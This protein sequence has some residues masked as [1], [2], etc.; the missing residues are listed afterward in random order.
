MDRGRK[1]SQI[2]TRFHLC[3]SM[4]NM[5]KVIK[6]ALIFC[7]Y[8]AGEGPS[9]AC[10]STPTPDAARIKASFTSASSAGGASASSSR[11]AGGGGSRPQ[12]PVPEAPGKSA[13]LE[14]DGCKQSSGLGAQGSVFT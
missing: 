6:E 3:I 9:H 8:S 13:A 7:P 12:C 1:A 2:N 4:R 5:F 11:G 14:R 10:V